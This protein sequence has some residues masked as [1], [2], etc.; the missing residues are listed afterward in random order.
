M[1]ILIETEPTKTLKQIKEDTGFIKSEIANQL[2]LDREQF[3][4]SNGLILLRGY[5]KE[6]NCWVNLT[7]VIG[8]FPEYLKNDLYSEYKLYCNVETK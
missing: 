8:K 3:K 4:L 6:N 1:K 2:G 7:N 5:S